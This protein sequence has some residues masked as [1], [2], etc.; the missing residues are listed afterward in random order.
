M[1]TAEIESSLKGL[2]ETLLT[3]L[4]CEKQPDLCN[5]MQ[6]CKVGTNGTPYLATARAPGYVKA[7]LE[8]QKQTLFRSIVFAALEESAQ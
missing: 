6:L 3:S 7:A 4:I 5:V 2:V 8:A 1:N